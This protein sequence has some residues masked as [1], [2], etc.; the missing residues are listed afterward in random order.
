MSQNIYCKPVLKINDVEIQHLESV[1][2]SDTGNNQLQKLSAT[3]TEPDLENF[4]LF[5]AKVEF[6]LNYGSSDG[7]PIFRGFVKDFNPSGKNVA[8]NALDVRTLLSGD[9]SF[10]IVIDDKK[11][12]DGQTVTA[13][14]ID[15]LDQMNNDLIK[16]TTLNDIDKP[17]YM[18]DI[19][20]TS[21]PYDI[22]TNTLRKALDDDDLL[23]P[24]SYEFDVVHLEQHSSLKIIKQK[25]IT[26]SPSQH[27][28][29]HDGI[30]SCVYKDRVSP[31]FA[32]AE[33]TEGQQVIFE[34]GNAPKG[35]VGLRVSGN[36][37]S[38]GEAKE[39]LI[40]QLMS[41]QDTEKD[42]KLTVSKG[43]YTNLGDIVKINVNDDNLNGQYRVTSKSITFAKQNAQCILQL[44]KKPI[45]VS[46][47]ILAA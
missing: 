41:V 27:F 9:N 47:Y 20:V 19:R 42:I 30:I 29:Y 31:S 16:S 6:Y 21:S 8:I 39:K 12:Y 40:P 46:D 22:A 7:C 33:T 37:N 26:S 34:F 25:Q 4:T 38:R 28:S 14:L 43:F 32:L 2:F 24:L 35:N 17:V 10:P 15:V 13:F 23:K 3:I 36:F 44:N 5:N 45:I 18:T 1:K 11:N